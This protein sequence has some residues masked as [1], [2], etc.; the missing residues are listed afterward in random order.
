VAAGGNRDEGMTVTAAGT[1]EVMAVGKAASTVAA[2]AVQGG[3]A[4]YGT[5]ARHGWTLAAETRVTAS[6]AEGRRA[7]QAWK[8]GGVS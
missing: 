6:A 2:A 5:A 3:E 7:G 8:A 4:A 1:S